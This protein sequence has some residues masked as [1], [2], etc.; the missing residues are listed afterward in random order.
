MVVWQHN[1]KL[2]NKINNPEINSS[3]KYMMRMAFQTIG[4]KTDLKKK[5]KRPS[6]DRLIFL[7]KIFFNTCNIIDGSEALC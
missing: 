5:K 6:P 1:Q 4:N 7:K 2:W 3:T